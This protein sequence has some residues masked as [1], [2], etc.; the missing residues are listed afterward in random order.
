M[1]RILIT[2]S[3]GALGY[4]L[5]RTLL[6]RNGTPQ[7]EVFGL[8]RNSA[9]DT[10]LK[11]FHTVQ[12]DVLS[13]T[14][15]K[16]VL[17]DIKPDVI[18]HLAWETAHASYWN[19]PI[20]RDWTDASIALATR[21][22]EQGGNYFGF[23]GTCAEYAWGDEVLDER[24]TLQDPAT[25]YGREKLR[26]TKALLS[27]GETVPTIV[28]C[29]RIFFPFCPQENENRITSLLVR[30]LLEGKEMHLRSAD[31]YRSICHT[32]HVAR[33][34]CSM[35]DSKAEGIFNVVPKRRM[36]LGQF[37][38]MIATAMGAEASVSWDEWGSTPKNTPNAVENDPRYLCGTGEKVSPYFPANVNLDEDIASFVKESS[39]RFS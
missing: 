36:H 21:F 32:K 24:S 12:A 16:T 25:L 34:L 38:K 39:A 35:A 30:N 9:T 22:S 31:V 26:T 6:E 28:N 3:Q 33:T 7:N 19:D 27:L 18:F 23:A 29:S 20:N 37:L 11:N 10:Y 1:Q 17:A 15:M 13:D 4:Y 14:A 8:S 2:G 5:K